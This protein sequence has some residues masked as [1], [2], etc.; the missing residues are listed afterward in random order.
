MKDVTF[1]FISLCSCSGAR[2]SSKALTSV[3]IMTTESHRYKS[4]NGFTLAQMYAL[5]SAIVERK[6]SIFYI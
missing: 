3:D 4:I 5:F 6:E 2:H 1:S